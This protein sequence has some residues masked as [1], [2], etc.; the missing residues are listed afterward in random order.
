MLVLDPV[1]GQYSAESTPEFGEDTLET[2][3]WTLLER[4]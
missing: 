3:Y 2:H 4:I 1:T